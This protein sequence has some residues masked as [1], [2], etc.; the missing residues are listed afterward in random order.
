[1]TLP[2]TTTTISVLR[3]AGGSQD[4]YDEKL[5]PTA[6]ATGIPA[7]ISTSSGDET[8]QG[9]SQEVTE[10]RLDCDPT[11]VTF[12][13]QIKDERTNEVYEVRWTRSRVDLPGLEYVQAG[14]KK[15]EGLV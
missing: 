12:L 10:F 4:P 14:L 8:V 7:H 15:V 5:P 13:D 3:N 1:M 11:D 9:G 6:I 2:L